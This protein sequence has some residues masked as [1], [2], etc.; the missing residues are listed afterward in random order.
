MLDAMET[1]LRD[2]IRYKNFIRTI[3]EERL[4]LPKGNL[5]YRNIKGHRYC[6]LQFK[7]ADGK[8]CNQRVLDTEIEDMQSRLERRTLLWEA[9]KQF[10]RCVDML[11]K[12]FPQLRS[13]VPSTVSDTQNRSADNRYR[14]YKG[15][16]VRS[17]S[18]LIIANELYANKISY[19][20]EKP[21]ILN[22]YANPFYPDFTICT[23]KEKRI[24]YWEPNY[25]LS[26]IFCVLFLSILNKPCN[27]G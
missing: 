1:I 20:Y 9:E 10:Q 7:D 12:T 4:Q 15:D 8:V 16:Y 19:E 11:D 3:K 18:E 27:Q 23:S 14:T 25:F 6:H 26:S 5:T 22:G 17:K 24:V 21:L 13:I 2:Y